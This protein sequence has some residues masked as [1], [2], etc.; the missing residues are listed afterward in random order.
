[1]AN[2]QI[3][4]RV[5]KVILEG[6]RRLEL[7]RDGQDIVT[8]LRIVFDIVKGRYLEPNTCNLTIYGLSTEQRAMCLQ[9]GMSVELYAGYQQDGA[10]LLYRGHTLWAAPERSGADWGVRLE[11]NDGHCPNPVSIKFDKGA[12]ASKILDS[13]A[14]LMPGSNGKVGSLGKGVIKDQPTG[15]LEKGRVFVSTGRAVL[16]M[17]SRENELATSIQ[18]GNL[19]SH[20]LPSDTGEPIVDVGPDTG[21]EG[22]PTMIKAGIGN[23]VFA[24][25]GVEFSCRLRGDLTMGRPIRV[26]SEVFG[27]T[28]DNPDVRDCAVIKVSHS[29]DSWGAAWTT[30]VEAWYR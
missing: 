27:G 22:S 28:R 20:A 26:R 18:D 6:D 17:F 4:D 10:R 3:W 25:P 14:Q 29:G 1:M 15:L 19:Q 12:Q 9:R 8:G 21:L 16:E 13:L 24:A 11:C 5:W 23:Q 2:Y 30:R 7:Y